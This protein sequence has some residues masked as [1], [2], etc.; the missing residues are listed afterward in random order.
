MRIRNEYSENVHWRAFKPDDTV[1]LTGITQGVVEP[2]R[3]TTWREDS[4][5]SFK[6][7]AK[8]G[9]IVFSSKVLAPAGRI[10]KMTDDLVVSRDGT[11]DLAQVKFVYREP[12][13]I[14]GS[15]IQF[16]DARK[17]DAPW[18]RTVKSKAEAA[19]SETRVTETIASREQT[20]T[21]G[22]KL[23]GALGKQDGSHANAEL[24]AQFEDKVVTSLRT[25][26]EKALTQTWEKE[27]SDTLTFSPG[28]LYVVETIWTFTFDR[29]TA[30]YFGEA[31]DFTVVR[32]AQPGIL[33]PL[34]FDG[35]ENFPE[36]YMKTWHLHGQTAKA[37]V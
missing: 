15:H 37:Q 33:R 1:Y 20:W 34:A 25:S 29:G 8:L 4:Y 3:V 36:Q 35:P 23:G 14:H 13:H 6:V 9:D 22:G 2:G 12:E 21:V 17:N 16:F 7:E 30:T 27:V 24:S 28:K 11:L 19:F 10:F 31:T 5:G 32:S 26:H 18:S